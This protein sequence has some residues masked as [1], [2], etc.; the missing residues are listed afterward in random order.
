VGLGIIPVSAEKLGD[1]PTSCLPLDVPERKVDAGQRR[2]I[3]ADRL[4]ALGDQRM[5]PSMDGFEIA[6]VH[7]PDC[8]SEM[9]I[10]HRRHSMREEA[11]SHADADMAFVGL[12]LA[13]DAGRIAGRLADER[14]ACLEDM[15]AG[16]G[17]HYR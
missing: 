8:R 10:D 1:G 11:G 14:K 2:E 12:D 16:K 9:M 7:S 4:A 6:R 5:E 13:D 3:D 17:I 15:H